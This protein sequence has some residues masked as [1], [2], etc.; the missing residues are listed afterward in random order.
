MSVIVKNES[1]DIFKL[2]TKGS[3]EKLRE[4]C[5]SETIP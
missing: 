5:K 3:P 1:E 2:Y 4:L